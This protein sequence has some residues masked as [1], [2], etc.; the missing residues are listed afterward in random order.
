MPPSRK[1]KTPAKIRLDDHVG[2]ITGIGP[3]KSDTLVKAGFASVFDLLR[4]YPVRYQDRRLAVMIGSLQPQAQSLVRATLQSI[5]SYHARRGL[6]VI[7]AEFSDSSGKIVARWFNRVY[8]IRQLIPGHD[9]WLFGT[10]DCARG[11]PIL[12]NPEIEAVDPDVVSTPKKQ[13]TPVYPANARLSEARI[14]PLALRKLIDNV[15][16][17][18]DWAASFPE[19][20][21]A[22]SFNV[23]ANAL[24]DIHRPES[25]EHLK[26]ARHTLAFFDQVLFQMG[27][28]KRREN[29]TGFLSLPDAM[30]HPPSDSPYPLP[31]K[32][33]AG[34]R[35][36]LG[37]IIA[38]LQPEPDKPPMNRLLQGDVGSGKTLVAFLAMMHFALELSPGSQC[39]FMAPTEILA[40]QHLQSF[41]RFFPEFA[42]LAMVVTGSLKTAGRKQV[43]S[44]AAS[45]D[46]RFIFGTHALFQ[47]Q[48]QFNR[49]DLCIIDEQQ[50]FGVN[51]RRQLFRKGTNPHQ[52]LLSATPIPRTLSLTI[53]GDM[54]TSTINEMPPGR[55]PVA[56]NLVSSFAEALPAI[57]ATLHGKNQIYIVCPLIETSENSER[58]SVEEAADRVSDYVPEASFACLTGNQTWEEKE[59]IMHEFKAG[60]LDIIIATTVVEVGVDNPRA[61]LMIIEN[62]DCFGLS[63]LHQLRGRVG[64][65]SE[66]STCV[67]IS[68]AVQGSERLAILAST[69]DGFALSMEDLR[70]RGPG[71]LVGTRQSG[72]SHPCFSHH[73]PQK[74]V[75]N[76]RTRAFEI[77]T[78]EPVEI[79]EWFYGQMVKS[80]GESY[81]TFMEGG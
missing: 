40:R 37:E 27:V 62:A 69:N 44:A 8:L 39:A 72:L 24:E 49:L 3:K 38:D 23:I 9:Y 71:D 21:R 68:A 25:D 32:M 13:L 66:A 74:L 46:A 59:Q 65:G 73:I 64:R 42:H 5:K 58:V 19:A 7:N 52:L 34:Q 43:N 4:I 50:R 35:Q 11:Q 63:Q 36:A 54:D 18:V 51:H 1:V 22:S 75:E 78:S 31:F 26:K 55:L 53:F 61:T 20:V 17:Q 6:T 28:L 33:T 2:I 80:F 57:R 56:T 30:K 29:I 48:T 79:R 16:D 47:E 60:R 77:L 81:R 14:S 45:G 70:M 12:A 15:L 41:A 67:L 10:V 76:A